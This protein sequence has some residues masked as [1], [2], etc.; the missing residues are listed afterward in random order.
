MLVRNPKI[1]AEITGKI[2]IGCEWEHRIDLAQD[3]GERWAVVNAEVEP[4][5]PESWKLPDY[6]CVINFSSRTK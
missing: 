2:E 1:L 6:R 3:R 5:F 4:Q